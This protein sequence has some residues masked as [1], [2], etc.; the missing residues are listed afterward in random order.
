MV[1]A[2]K[3]IAVIYP[4]EEL[5][6]AAAKCTEKLLKSASN[7]LKCMGIWTLSS[8]VKVDP[9]FAV[10]YQVFIGILKNFNRQEV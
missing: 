7:N 9:R 3:T 2:A 4:N 10:Q 8:V 6:Q 1:E 5:V